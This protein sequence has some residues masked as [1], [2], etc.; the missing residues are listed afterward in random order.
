MFCE[1]TAFYSQFRVCLQKFGVS[2]PAGLGVV[3]VRSAPTSFPNLLNR[4]SVNTAYS[5]YT[6]DMH[7]LKQYSV[8]TH[9]LKQYSVDMHLLKQYSV[10]TR[11]Y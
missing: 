10:D 7:L 3:L 6:A 8:D 5:Q 1:Q 2:R 4:Y 11:L 9:L